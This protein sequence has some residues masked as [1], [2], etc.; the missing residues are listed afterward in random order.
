MSFTFNSE[1]V[2]GLDREFI[3]QNITTEPEAAWRAVNPDGG[4]PP[5][6]VS[7]GLGLG[8]GLGS[9]FG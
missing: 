2:G 7:L 1:D 8:T 6:Q 3:E 5:P 4:E 9:G